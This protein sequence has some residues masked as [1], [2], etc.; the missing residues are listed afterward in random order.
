MVRYIPPLG[1]GGARAK[2]RITTTATGMGTRNAVDNLDKEG[3]GQH[4]DDP[5]KLSLSA[6][7]ACSALGRWRVD[8]HF[9]TVQVVGVAK[10][11]K[12]TC[13][14]EQESQVQEEG[15]QLAISNT[16]ANPSLATHAANLLDP[17]GSRIGTPFDTSCTVQEQL[18]L[19]DWEEITDK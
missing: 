11:R 6:C 17:K 2:P 3:T 18:E 13:M 5:E 16:F 7:Y 15:A 12:R 14:S 10:T 1:T 9:F 8:P 4:S 19:L